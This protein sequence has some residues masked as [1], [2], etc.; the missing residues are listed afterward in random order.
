MDTINRLAIVFI[1]VMGIIMPSVSSGAEEVAKSP[2]LEKGI[3]AYKHE[4]YE[5]ALPLLIQ[6][7]EEDPNSTLAA[8]YL[9]LDYKQLQNYRKAI[10]HLRDAVSKPPKIKGALIELIDCLYNYN[11]LDEANKW[12][13][14]AQ[15][16][17]IRPAQID[18]LKGLVLVQ[19]EQYEDAIASFEQA[20]E[21]DPS[22]AQA[23]D[24][25]IGV[26]QLKA[27]EFD[28]ARK[29]FEMAADLL[30]LS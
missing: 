25:Q 5:E 21:R 1:T 13:D 10:P 28:K 20:K 19:Q 15:R 17:G 8:Y 3:G 14:E 24:Y 26:A 11:E 2:T 30:P 7:R 16:E 9:G 6:A 4:N 29:T 23:S 18:F 27:K 12:I 22:M